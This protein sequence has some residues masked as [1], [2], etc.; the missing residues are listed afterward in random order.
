MEG[1]VFSS[2]DNKIIDNRGLPSEEWKKPEALKL[3]SQFEGKEIAAFMGWNGI[4]VKSDRV[5]I[6]D[7]TCGYLEEVQGFSCGRCVPCRIGTRVMLETVQ[8]IVNDRGKEEDLQR[9]EDLGK[10]II[11]GSKCEIGKSSPVPVFHAISYYRAD[12]LSVIQGKRTVKKGSYQ[13]HLTA[14]CMDACP[15]HLDVPTYVELI[16]ERRFEEALELIRKRNALPGVCG[17]VC[18][19]PCEFSCRRNF[20]DEPVQ[21]KFLKRFVADYEIAHQLESPIISAEKTPDRVAVIG[22]GPAGVSCAFYLAQ[23]GYQVTIFEA[24]PEPGGM[25]AVGIPDYRLPRAILRREVEIVQKAGV[26]I[27]YNTR[28]GVD[29]TMDD[30]W[31]EGY[32]AIFIGVGSHDS[33]AMG[34]EGE[35]KGYQGFIPGVKF[36]RDIN[37]GKEIYKGDKLMVVGGGNVAIDCARSAFRV[38]FKEVNLVY[39]RSRKEMPADAVEIE[40][41]EKEGVKF[42]F[43]TLPT[44]IIAEGNKVKAVECIRMELGEPDSSGRRRPIPVKGSEFILETDVLIPAIGQDQDLSFIRESDGVVITKWGTVKVDED[45][46]MS[47]R[48]GIFSGGD[49][50]TGPAALVNALSAGYD[51]AITI[52]HYLNREPLDLTDIRK[53]EKF[54]NQF[55]DYSKEEKVSAVSGLQK[56]TM[57]HLPIDT[58]IHTFEEVE[59]GFDAQSAIRDASRCLRCYRV[60]LMALSED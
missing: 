52:D 5:D 16:K 51:A 20:L 9:L 56:S 22:A 54:I 45:N 33:K 36:L 6:V 55:E 1:I 17:R 31:K 12:F 10:A 29:K 58:R 18:I 21:I 3:P 37:V 59:F 38:G 23:K 41:A 40:D 46:L 39:R 2:W 42:H 7:M 47:D 43:L 48:K 35:E 24:L 19:R 27:I 60:A 53:K 30:L 34:V 32:Q 44:K 14:P 8:K 28:I 49:C 13:S 26:E 25:A 4:I 57:K 50:V 11:E 15:V